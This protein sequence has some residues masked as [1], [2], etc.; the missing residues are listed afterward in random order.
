MIVV[1][2]LNRV[3]VRNESEGEIALYSKVSLQRK[4][5]IAKGEIHAIHEVNIGMV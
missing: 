1:W 5:A 4:E 3:R 2:D